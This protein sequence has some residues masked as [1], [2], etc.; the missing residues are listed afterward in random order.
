MKTL[1][2][3]VRRLVFALLFFSASIGFVNP[4][5][6]ADPPED[7]EFDPLV[8]LQK[9]QQSYANQEIMPQNNTNTG[10]ATYAIAVKV[11]PGRGGLQ[12]GISISYSSSAKNGWIGVGWNLDLG[13]IQRATKR[14][15]D[16]GGSD[17]LYNGSTELISRADW[18][19]DFYGARIEE[20]FSKFFFDSSTGGWEVTA[21][22][23]T[24]HFYGSSLDSR[25][26]D[27]VNTARV[28]KWCLDRVE[29]TNGNTMSVTYEKD[30]GQI[31][32]SRI[33]YTD[34][35][36]YVLFTTEPRSDVRSS[37]A[38]GFLITTARRLNQIRVFGNNV[39]A[40]TYDLQYETSVFSGRSRL[41][42]VTENSLPP[43]LFSYLPGGVGACNPDPSHTTATDVMVDEIGRINFAD[44]NA[45]AL[46]DLIKRDAY[47]I[48]YTYLSLGDGRFGPVNTTPTGVLAGESSYIDFVDIDGDGRSDL[49]KHNLNGAFMVHL[50]LGDGKFEQEGNLTQTD[51]MSGEF[52]DVH[53]ADVNGD[54]L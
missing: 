40:R 14:G 37:L 25:Q 18:G 7:P 42:R 12:P 29:D 20:G 51:V 4:V 13:S 10:A 45:D 31:Y 8:S 38:P 49:V 22:D 36:N 43:T 39:L 9:F 34:G 19:V 44:I 48:F 50:S 23:G 3:T 17:F 53:F 27:P 54:G 52:N 2:T 33:D 26:H 16:Y 46:P 15:L 32:P 41:I 30:Q 5:Q 1:G 21:K 6:G 11:T 28:F 35:T 47:G 24:R